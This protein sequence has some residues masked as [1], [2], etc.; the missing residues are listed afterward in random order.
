MYMSVYSS[1]LIIIT[2]FVHHPGSSGSLFVWSS[3]LI[4]FVLV[5]FFFVQPTSL[6]PL[7]LS[8]Q[9]LF[10]QPKETSQRTGRYL[11]CHIML[12]SDRF[13]WNVFERD[14]TWCSPLLLLLLLP[15]PRLKN[16]LAEKVISIKNIL[17][18]FIMLL[19]E[20]H[21]IYY[22]TYLYFTYNACTLF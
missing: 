16:R 15:F 10:N 14:M 18:Y 13:M 2:S 21:N 6:R 19:S 8:H 5:P 11:P 17:F 12:T 4:F 22:S 9:N 20:R 3:R 7:P 1:I